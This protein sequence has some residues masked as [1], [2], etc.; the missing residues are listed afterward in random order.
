MFFYLLKFIFLKNNPDHSS[1]SPLGALNQ[2]LLFGHAF[3]RVFLPVFG[4]KVPF[5]TPALKGLTFVNIDH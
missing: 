2:G 1:L 3:S 4:W 5:H